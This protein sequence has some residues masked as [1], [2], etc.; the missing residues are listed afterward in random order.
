MWSLKS[1]YPVYDLIK[2]VQQQG[3]TD[4]GAAT[5]CFPGTIPLNKCSSSLV[6]EIR[7]SLEHRGVRGRPAWLCAS[8]LLPLLLRSQAIG[9]VIRVSHVQ[10]VSKEIII[11]KP[12]SAIA[13]RQNIQ[14]RDIDEC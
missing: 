10:H 1:H 6:T 8:A 4:T 7:K 5:A 11:L 12:A 3:S 9:I 13:G 2:P 14:A